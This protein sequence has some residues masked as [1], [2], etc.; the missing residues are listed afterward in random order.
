MQRADPADRE[1]QEGIARVWR[2]VGGAGLTEP[3]R[4]M[5]RAWTLGALKALQD[6]ADRA[7]ARGDHALCA[8]NLHRM[9]GIDPANQKVRACL[10]EVLAGAGRGEEAAAVCFDL[11]E[12]LRRKGHLKEARRALARALELCP[13]HQVYE[14]ALEQLEAGDGEARD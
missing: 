14:E 4:E 5:G 2:V 6:L 7:L 9:L 8:A 12:A 3:N 11:A 13:G 1:V 10:S